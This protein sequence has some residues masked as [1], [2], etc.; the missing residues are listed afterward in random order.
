MKTR[1]IRQVSLFALIPLLFGAV[2]YAP[3]LG[4]QSKESPARRNPLE[5]IPVTGTIVTGGTFQGTLDIVSFGTDDAGALVAN[6]LLDGVLRP[7]SGGNL[8]VTDKYVT[9]PVST[10]EPG[11]SNEPQRTCSILHLELGPLFLDLLG[12]QVSLNRVVLD[13]DAVTGP[14]NLLGNLLCA[15]VS[16]LDDPLG[17]LNNIIGLLNRVI[18]LLGR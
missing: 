17:N 4:A 2:F 18:D 16:L 12:L 13:I 1:L 11:A 8:Q 9:L 15:I 6:G 10:I 5:R 3:S 14:G 7:T